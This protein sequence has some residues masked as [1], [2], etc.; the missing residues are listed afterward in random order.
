[1]NSDTGVN[2]MLNYDNVD[3]PFLFFIKVFIGVLGGLFI[4]SLIDSICRILQNDN[5]IDWRERD[6]KNAIIY[7]ILQIFINIS[8]LLL[9]S[10]IFPFE[11]IQ[12]LQLTISGSLFVTLLFITQQ[13]LVNNSIRIFYINKNE[14]F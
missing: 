4:G 7:F 2:E 14:I 3:K 10:T 6:L 9:L 13:N 1:M 8:I 11:F 5:S 12:W